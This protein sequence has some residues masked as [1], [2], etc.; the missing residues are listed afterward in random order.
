MANQY[1]TNLGTVPQSKTTLTEARKRVLALDEWFV[2]YLNTD[3]RNAIA[4]GV[5][6]FDGQDDAIFYDGESHHGFRLS[7]E[8][9]LFLVNSSNNG[10]YKFIV[11][12]KTK[13]E[14]LWR[15]WKENKKSPK[16]IVNANKKN[17]TVQAAGE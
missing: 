8:K 13:G 7:F 16:E 17:K 1:R 14:N 5:E 3:T 6:A 9:V 12:H 10:V 4:Q 11:Y 15:K 2:E